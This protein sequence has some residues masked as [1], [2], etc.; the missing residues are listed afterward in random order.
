MIIK[1]SNG[2]VENRKSLKKGVPQN[3]LA[4]VQIL[5]VFLDRSI[6]KKTHFLGSL[7]WVLFNFY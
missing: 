3:L 5:V 4:R 2:L 1:I 6:L 7:R